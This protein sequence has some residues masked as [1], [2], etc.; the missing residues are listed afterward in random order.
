MFL[1][2]SASN[3]GFENPISI[4]V[5]ENETLKKKGVGGSFLLALR[6]CLSAALLTASHD[7]W[8]VPVWKRVDKHAVLCSPNPGSHAFWQV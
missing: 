8:A 6:Y 1:K 3:S 7:E 2:A 5:L 4:P